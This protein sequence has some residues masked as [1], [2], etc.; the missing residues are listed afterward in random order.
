MATLT[1]STTR[2]TT[3]TAAAVKFFRCYDSM[4]RY[5]NYRY[6][7]E[8]ADRIVDAPAGWCKNM[9][10]EDRPYGSFYWFRTRRGTVGF[11]IAEADKNYALRAEDSDTTPVYDDEHYLRQQE[12]M[13]AY[14]HSGAGLDNYYRDR[15]AGYVE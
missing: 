7:R 10:G 3:A 8:T 11:K 12:N 14:I 9:W 13:A 5:L 1:A 6:G 4:K 2:T 15:E